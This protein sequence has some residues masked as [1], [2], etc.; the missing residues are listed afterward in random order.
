MPPVSTP[1]L[2]GCVVVPPVST[3]ELEGCVVV[4]ATREHPR[5]GRLCS[6][7]VRGSPIGTRSLLSVEKS[8]LDLGHDYDLYWILYACLATGVNMQY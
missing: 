1:E 7:P 5:A 2:E 3:P 8:L 4:S 6:G